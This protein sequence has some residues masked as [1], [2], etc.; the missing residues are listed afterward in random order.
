MTAQPLNGEGWVGTWPEAAASIRYESSVLL[1]AVGQ[2]AALPVATEEG[3]DDKVRALLAHFADTTDA[4]PG[5]LS[6]PALTAA[7][8]TLREAASKSSQPQNGHKV[9][10]ML[11]DK[12]S[13]R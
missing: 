9:V 1:A 4:A 8:G 2:V 13:P 7:L 6:D 3:G 5:D 12:D 10:S 11:L